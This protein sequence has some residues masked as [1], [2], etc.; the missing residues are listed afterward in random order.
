MHQCHA[1]AARQPLSRRHPSYSLP[2][3]YTALAAALALPLPAQAAVSL[4]TV[5]DDPA[6]DYRTSEHANALQLA[7]AAVPQSVPSGDLWIIRV[8]R[9]GSYAAT[10]I[11]VFNRALLIEG[12][13]A[14]CA[15]VAA[16]ASNTVID[17]GGADAAVVHVSNNSERRRVGL[18]NL[19]L[20]GSRGLQGRGLD[21][22]SA[23]VE[24]R[25]VRIQDHAGAIRGGGA[26]VQ[27]NTLGASLTLSGG[28]VVSGNTATEQGG[29]IY[30]ARNA[31][32]A[33]ES[34]ST[35][36]GNSARSGG[37]VY[38]NACSG[39]INSGATG[40][41]ALGVNISSNTASFGGGGIYLASTFGPTDFVIGHGL[42]VDD[43]RP[44]LLA[45]TADVQGGG[46]YATGDQTTLQ[47]NN[48]AVL[49]NESGSTGG[50]IQVRSGAQVTM[51]QTL[52]YCGGTTQCSDLSSNTANYGGAVAVG[53]DGAHLVV[54]RTYISANTASGHGSVLFNQSQGAF[55]R[56][57]NVLM[58]HNEGP[59]VVYASDPNSSPPLTTTTQIIAATI[60]DNTGTDVML[61]FNSEG[62]AL[63]GHSIL[64]DD[65]GTP[66]LEFAAGNEPTARCNVFHQSGGLGSP[67]VSVSS[68]P[69]F[70]DA[71]AGN[72]R[73]HPFAFA[74]DRCAVEPGYPAMDIAFT[75]RPYDM[76]FPNI[77]GAIDAGTYEATEVVFRDGF[78]SPT[79]LG[80]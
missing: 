51:Q 26:R 53:S 29:G 35:V 33:L 10:T 18:A 68:D 46:I 71:A 66:P 61:D 8:A 54:R 25:R 76:P 24:L 58:H 38:V 1:R 55:A 78:E 20:S 52:P 49:G 79:P 44:L 30:C 57:E 27:G 41:A 60:A 13:Y 14:T 77:D 31:E 62:A 11:D 65:A 37:G 22:A 47:V 70:V 67:E 56:L 75:P 7:I 64:H 74:L 2:A 36:S 19:T 69:G 15:S 12:G 6:C 45:N 17:S 59:E 9:S 39:Y 4:I 50:G 73:L 3:L 43:P 72:Y 32:L 40:F 28:S 5:G 23:D 80:P 48:A 42:G 16:G 21:I 34:D 63:I